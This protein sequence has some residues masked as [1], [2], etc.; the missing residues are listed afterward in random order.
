MSNFLSIQISGQ[1]LYPSNTELILMELPTM[2]L[3]FVVI[4]FFCPV[5][6]EFLTHFTFQKN[7]V[8]IVWAAFHV[9]IQK[10]LSFATVTFS[11]F[12]ELACIHSILCSMIIFNML[13]QAL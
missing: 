2:D 10:G 6:C 13:A 9:L 7:Y 12:T 8:W 5:S 4:Y 1:N 11:I 3:L